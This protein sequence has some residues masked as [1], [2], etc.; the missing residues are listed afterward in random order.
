MGVHKIHH[1]V[2]RFIRIPAGTTAG[3]IYIWWPQGWNN[4]GF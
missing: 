1:T 3:N 2:H 4:L